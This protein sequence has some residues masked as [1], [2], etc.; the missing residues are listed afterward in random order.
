MADTF[1]RIRNASHTSSLKKWMLKNRADFAAALADA[2]QPDWQAIAV[3][4]D[5]IGL[6]ARGGVPLSANTVRMAWTRILDADKK[7]KSLAP[8][9]TAIVPHA[10]TVE[11]APVPEPEPT[12]EATERLE[13][14][15]RIM[16]ER[17]RR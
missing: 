3:Q 5:R 10:K 6:T 12:S 2:G 13:R 4:L 14:N 1:E 16:Q 8:V 9:K 11:R 15:R 7:S 17:S